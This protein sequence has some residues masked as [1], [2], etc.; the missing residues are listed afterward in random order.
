MFGWWCLGGDVW[1][2]VF[3]WCWWLSAERARHVSDAWLPLVTFVRSTWFSDAIPEAR[4]HTDLKE[5]VRGCK[6]NDLKGYVKMYESNG[7]WWCQEMSRYKSR[8]RDMKRSHV[9]HPLQS[10]HAHPPWQLNAWEHPL[11]CAEQPL[12]CKTQHNHDGPDDRPDPSSIHFNAS[13]TSDKARS[14]NPLPRRVTTLRYSSL[15]YSFKGRTSEVSQLKFLWWYITASILDFY[16]S[17]II[18]IE[19]CITLTFVRTNAIFCLESQVASHQTGLLCI[20]GHL[21]MSQRLTLH[22]RFHNGQ[23]ADGKWWIY[24]RNEHS[25]MRHEKRRSTSQFMQQMLQPQAV[26][27]IPV[28]CT[29]SAW[30]ACLDNPLVAS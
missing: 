12:R 7:P 11:Q 21:H 23:M 8:K 20:K 14:P 26:Q 9:K 1:V 17:Y 18:V 24:K 29:R 4:S 19:H 5:C 10:A 2:V 3:W 22:P 30:L 16:I 27:A 6:S 15:L 25:E 28:P 13:A